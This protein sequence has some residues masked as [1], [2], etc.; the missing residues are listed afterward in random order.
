MKWLKRLLMT[1]GV[2]VLGE[3]PATAQMYTPPPTAYAPAPAADSSYRVLRLRNVAA[4]D[5]AKALSAWAEGERRQVGFA[6]DAEANSITV[7]GDLASR[8]RAFDVLSALDR[9]PTQVV[10]ELRYIRVPAGFC[11]RLGL[12][13]SDGAN[14]PLNEREMRLFMEA[15]QLN[16]DCSVLMA[17]KMTL[18]DNQTATVK[19]E[20]RQHF[21]TAVE[22]V[23]VNGET[24]FVPQ[25]KA[26]DLGDWTTLCGRVSPDGKSVNLRVHATRKRLV[27]DVPLVPVV[28]QVTPV[29]EGGSRGKPVPFT[30]YL[31]VPKIETASIERTLAVP[32]GTTAVVGVWKEVAVKIIHP[33]AASELIAS[34]AGAFGGEPKAEPTTTEVIILATVRVCCP[35]ECERGAKP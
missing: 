22:A 28:T 23:N 21:V 33:N 12:K 9:D 5:A 1:L 25:N 3:A 30:Q 29:F 27:G 17:P 7:F 18:F 15:V 34:F 2:A 20:E 26:V 8:Q 10:V 31:Q 4:A 32:S 6:F 35:M 19:C 24:V 11:E 14:A 13:P 16:R